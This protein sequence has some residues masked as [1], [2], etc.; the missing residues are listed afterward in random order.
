MHFKQPEI[1][2]FLFLLIVPILVHL[3]QLRR[4]KKEYFTNVR[5]LKA[6]S[7]QTRKS[8]KIKK[9]LLL[10]CRLLLL[11]CIILAFTQP[12]FESKDSKNVNNEMYI[13]LDNSFS[14]Q[15][16][17]KKGELLKRAI[18]EL[19]EETPENANFSLLTNTDSYWDTDIRTIRNELQNLKYSAVPFQLDNILAKV[20]AHK[21]AFKK[22][23]VV[24]TDAVGLTPN[25]LKNIETDDIPYFIIP[26]AEQKNNVA[27]DSVF[28]RQTLDDFYELSINTTNYSED[29]KPVSMALYNQNKLIAKTIINFKNKK[30]T[31]NFTIPKQAFHGY[32]SIED[33]DLGY[34][35]KLFFSI[36]KIKKNNIISIGTP[37]KNNFL[38]RIYTNDEFNYSS[39]TLNTLDYNS[40][41]KQDAIILNEL[42]EIPQALQT[43]LKAFVKKGGN[44]IV[45]P[46]ETASVS[47]LNA[48]L[49]QFGST[50]FK[51]L[52]SNEKLI[53]KINFSH[54]LFAGVFENKT[55]N[56]QYPKIKKDFTVS[57]TNPAILIFDDKSPFLIG[58]QNTAS[59]VY[60]FSAPLN[61]LNSNFQQSPLIVPV[62]YKMALSKLNNGINSN[63]IGNNT[64]Y[65]VSVNLAKD[66]IL[67]VKNQDEQFIPVQQL[68]NNKVQL[69]FNDYPEKAGNYTI[70]DSKKPIENI[71]FNYPRTESNLDQVNETLLSD[72]K[73]SDSISTIFDTLQS[74]RNDN[75]I[76]KW[77][78]IFAL[79]FLALEMAIIKFVK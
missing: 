39:F 28:I 29:F 72:Y 66:E 61:T 7:I 5:F 27:I 13:I 63:I 78:I 52:E 24:I 31:I 67:T 51:S 34:D 53:T 62:F 23:I 2:Y 4:F 70:Y 55:N 38:S 26:K 75:Q 20:K 58:L 65:L 25:Q 57:T 74:N 60:V 15:A 6:L 32:V 50:Q 3:F 69:F 17:G 73:T 42:D 35:N 64:S 40:I 48:L 1:L 59:S 8:S 47:S 37:E 41:E 33:N 19:L 12:F 77:F 18:Q 11:T 79:L 44:L 46:S 43:T 16:K 21:S 22:D 9:W 56:F 71:S 68:L 45:I 30:E 49:N 76:W 10:A 54:P 36:S 14:M